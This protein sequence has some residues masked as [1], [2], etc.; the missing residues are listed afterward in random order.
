[1]FESRSE[2]L[3][4]AEEIPESITIKAW[5]KKAREKNLYMV[6]GI[7]EKENNKLYNS[8][9]IIG[10]E[11]YIGI[12]RK[13]H[14]WFNEKLIFDAGNLYFPVFDLP[15]GRLGI[16]ICYDFYFPETTRILALQGSDIIV[17]PTNWPAEESENTWDKSGYCM[18]NYRAIAYA[19]GNKV[20]IACANRVGKERGQ[21]FSGSSI[22]T[23]PDGWPIAGPAGRD[24]EELII[25]EIDIMGNRR[26]KLLNLDESISDRRCD[27]YDEMLGYKKIPL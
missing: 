11:G 19:N 7:A 17:I 14:L 13:C 1:M 25:A 22:I 3:M 16:Q 23:G 9:V 6:A 2:L 15:F 5:V 18:G 20:Y 21:A 27:I 10:P 26:S 8:A 4:L 24:T 12:Y